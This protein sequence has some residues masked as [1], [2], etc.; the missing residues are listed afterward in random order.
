MADF[1]CR[2]IEENAEAFLNTGLGAEM[3]V[4]HSLSR[5]SNLKP[6]SW[7]AIET[8]VLDKFR[9]HLVSS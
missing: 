2:K 4:I 7:D 5:Y 1:M 6:K 9:K 8:M 3:K